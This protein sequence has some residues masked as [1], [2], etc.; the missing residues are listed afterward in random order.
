MPDEVFVEPNFALLHDEE[1]MARS[2]LT[3]TISFLLVTYGSRTVRQ[4]LTAIIENLPMLERAV[5][6]LRD[7]R[8]E[9]RG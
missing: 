4:A 1:E 2:F 3:T 6:A 5:A 8:T 9:G 7:T